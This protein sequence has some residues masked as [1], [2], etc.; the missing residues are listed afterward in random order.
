MKYQIQNNEHFTIQKGDLSLNVDDAIPALQMSYDG[1]AT[2]ATSGSY[3]DL[4]NKPTIPDAQI[5]SDWLQSDNTAKDF[6]KNKPTITNG[7]SAYQSY[8]DTTSDNPVKSESEWIASLKG[9][10]G[11]SLGEISLVQ[12]TGTSDISVMSQ[13]AVTEAIKDNVSVERGT[14]VKFGTKV[15]TKLNSRQ[16]ELLNSSTVMSMTFMMNG[17]DEDFSGGQDWRYIEIGAYSTDSNVLSFATTFWGAFYKREFPSNGIQYTVTAPLNRNVPHPVVCTLV[18]DREHGTVKFYKGTTLVNTDTRNE[19]KVTK[20]VGDDGVIIFYGGDYGCSFYGLQFYDFDIIRGGYLNQILNNAEISTVDV[21]MKTS[22]MQSHTFTDYTNIYQSSNYN[23]TTSN[24]ERIITRKD[25]AAGTF[26]L[27]GFSTQYDEFVVQ[28]T[29]DKRFKYG[30]WY[31]N[32]RLL[33][34]SN[35]IL[36]YDGQ[37]PDE[38]F[39]AGTYKMVAFWPRYSLGITTTEDGATLVIHSSQTRNVGCI[40]NFKFDALYNR[41]VYDD[42]ADRFYTFYSDSSCT[43]VTDNYSISS[44]PLRPIYIGDLTLPHYIGEIKIVGENVYIANGSWT[45]KRINN[46]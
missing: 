23:I 32:G 3:N 21:N 45:W 41:K 43:T 29:I 37:S 36:V 27:T 8:L 38:I 19:Y 18:C 24:G 46:A 30:G 6:I 4:T 9:D 33:Y 28:F 14:C 22:Y 16:I 2:V 44:L 20:F 10:S 7:K 11:V 31:I 34:D 39:E 26:Y 5:Q 35:G 1:L 15:Y 12:T 25:G 13:A 17:G 42:V 40:A